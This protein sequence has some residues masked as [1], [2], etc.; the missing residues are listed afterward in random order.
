MKA[1][2]SGD[3]LAYEEEERDWGVFL[4]RF[5]WRLRRAYAGLRY[6]KGALGDS[7]VIFGNSF[8]K[9]G[10]HLLAQIVLAFP[11]FG[12]AV[13]RGMGPVLTFVR[14][15]GRERSSREIL[16]DLKKL[17]PGDVAFGHITA[18]ADIMRE[19]NQKRVAHYFMVRDPRDVVVSHA[20]YIGDKATHNVHHEYYKALPTLDDRIRVS[21]LGRQDWEGNFPDI[22]S[23]Y[24]S[25]LGWLECPDVLELRFEDFITCR[26][27]FLGSMVDYAKSKGFLL[28]VTKEHAVEIL[29]AAVDPQRSYTFRSG[30]VGDWKEH[31]TEEHKRLFKEVTG[32]LL[33]RL[34]YEQ[35]STW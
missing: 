27:E 11:R 26:E 29:G 33:V 15:T 6:G 20:F 35:D 4:R 12:L 22:G 32:D 34:G 7:P 17:Y 28:R 14:Q 21:I 23:R 1:V 2:M 5:R 18:A 25:Y 19:L 30:R 3:P 13:D 16:G 31:F 9:S 10:T 8:P 24:R